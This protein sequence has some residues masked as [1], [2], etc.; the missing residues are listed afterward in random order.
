MRRNATIL[1]D[2]GGY[3]LAAS[4]MN[5]VIFEE[6]VGLLLDRE[7][8]AVVWEPFAGPVERSPLLDFASNVGVALISQTLNP[9][10]ERILAADSTIVGP[11]REIG[12]MLFHPPY[13]G[14]SSISSDKR[15]V[16]ACADKETYLNRLGC[17]VGQA[18]S[19]MARG[20]LV[21]SV[22]RDYRIGGK[23]VHLDLW[24][25]EMFEGGGYSLM[26]VWT[27]EPDVV[28]ILRRRRCHSK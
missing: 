25:L 7:V 14:S 23:R 5:P 20:G 11:G 13:Y 15:D 17:V 8:P 1:R 2:E 10:D 26:D 3:N 28:L 27:S 6:F 18:E 12:G 24:M 22:A 4:Q 9:V 16:V 21:C 19:C